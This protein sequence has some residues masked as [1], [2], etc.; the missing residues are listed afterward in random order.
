MIHSID[1]GMLRNE[2][3]QTVLSQ[4]AQISGL[5]VIAS[6]D[7]INSSLGKQKHYIYRSYDPH[8]EK[9]AFRISD[10]VQHKL[11]RTTTENGQQLEISDL[12]S[13][14]IVLSM[15]CKQRC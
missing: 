1:G 2:K 9:S 15:K 12:G 8:Q 13:R 14:E 7:H 6:I 5:H 4:L 10:Q 3:T 11:D